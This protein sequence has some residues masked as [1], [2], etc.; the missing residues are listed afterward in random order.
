MFLSVPNICGQRL[1]VNGLSRV[2]HGFGNVDESC[3]DEMFWN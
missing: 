3:V 2:N 1:E